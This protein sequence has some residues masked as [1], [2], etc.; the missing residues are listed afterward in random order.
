MRGVI[1]IFTLAIIVF[2][3]KSTVS[4]PLSVE[5]SVNYVASTVANTVNY[6]ICKLKIQ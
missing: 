3:L 2:Q 6:F 1:I 5:G 4:A